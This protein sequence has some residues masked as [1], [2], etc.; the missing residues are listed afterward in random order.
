MG[1]CGANRRELEDQSAIKGNLTNWDKTKLSLIL[2]SK[3][4]NVKKERGEEKK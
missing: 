2:G 3:K 4:K 1:S